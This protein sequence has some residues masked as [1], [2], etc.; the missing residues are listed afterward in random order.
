M[1]IIEAHINYEIEDR[2]LFDNIKLNI[3]KALINGI[4]SNCILVASLILPSKKVAL[5]L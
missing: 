5:S 4:A 3:N 1:N 2:I